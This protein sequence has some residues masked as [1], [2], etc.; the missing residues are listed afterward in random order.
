MRV[1]VTGATGFIGSAIVREFVHAGHQVLGL[2]RSAAGTKSLIAAG[3]E[4]HLGDLE[5][6]ERLR[7][8]ASMCDGVI[9]TAFVHDFTNWKMSCEIDRQAIEALGSGLAGSNRPLVAASG[10]GVARVAGQLATED[11]PQSIS[12]GIPRTASEEAVQA[13]TA[14]GVP[15]SVVRLPPTVHGEGDNGF[16]PEMVAIARKRGVSAY[17][18]DG[19]NRWPAVHRLDAARLFRLA[20]EK[21]TAGTTYNG[22]ADEGVPIREI[23]EVIGRRLRL[24]IVGKSAG[25]AIEHFGFLG[26]LLNLDM[27]ASSKA[28]QKLLGWRPRQPGLISDLDHVRYF[29]TVIPALN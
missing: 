29:E 12:T 22:I 11:D 15:A 24:P 3:A 19:F 7:L 10:T 17:V 5:D 18:G 20:L 4:V 2:T 16:I 23:A 8:G 1:F 13:L 26:R 21:G 25:E 14:Q 28:T 27:P 9:H 6:P